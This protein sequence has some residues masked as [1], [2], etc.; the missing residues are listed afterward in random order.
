MLLPTPPSRRLRPR[1]VRVTRP[2]QPPATGDRATRKR[3][4][5]AGTHTNDPARHRPRTGVKEKQGNGQ[6]APAGNDQQTD[7][8]MG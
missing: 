1:R 6:L 7:A 2:H 8:T 5:A 4:W 3:P